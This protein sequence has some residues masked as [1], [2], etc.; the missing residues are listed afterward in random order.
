MRILQHLA[1]GKYTALGKTLPSMPVFLQNMQGSQLDDSLRIHVPR[2][3]QG[4]YDVRSRR[5]VGHLPGP[6]SA[7]RPDAELL[8]MVSRWV[9]AEFVRILSP[10]SNH[11]DAQ[12]A[13]DLL[14]VHDSP[15]VQDFEGAKRVI[16]TKALSVSARI[17]ILLFNLDSDAC[18][19]VDLVEWVRAPRKSVIQELSR[20]DRRDMIHRFPDGRATLTSLGRIKASELVAELSA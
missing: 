11:T 18:H 10:S 16:S 9:L 4:I 20:L 13:V 5:G 19:E 2:Q 8:L 3:L 12:K 7:N 1:T 14:A 17:L 6:V 15:L